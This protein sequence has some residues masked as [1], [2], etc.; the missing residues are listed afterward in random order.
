MKIATDYENDVT[1]EIGDELDE[2]STLRFCID[3]KQGC[4]QAAY[5]NRNEIAELQEHLQKIMD[6][7]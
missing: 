5:L 3:I 4:E 2:D 6:G 7:A 1:L